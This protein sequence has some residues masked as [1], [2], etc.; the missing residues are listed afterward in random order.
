MGS[1]NHID[2]LDGH[3]TCQNLNDPSFML[4]RKKGAKTKVDTLVLFMCAMENQVQPTLEAPC[5]S[6]MNS[7]GSNEQVVQT[8]DNCQNNYS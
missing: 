2:V 7:I 3:I 6:W 1:N 4:K 8:L 5:M